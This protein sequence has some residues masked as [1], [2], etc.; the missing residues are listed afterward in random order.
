MICYFAIKRNELIIRATEW[1]N[2]DTIMLSKQIQ[3]Q[4]TTCFMIPFI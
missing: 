3:S 1:M 4:N 2:L